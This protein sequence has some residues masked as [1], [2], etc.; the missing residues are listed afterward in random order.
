MTGRRRR[1]PAATAKSTPPRAH[2][3]QAD[4]AAAEPG[5]LAAV[6]QVGCSRSPLPD[7]RPLLAR[8]RRRLSR[9]RPRV[10][11]RRTCKSAYPMLAPPRRAATRRPTQAAWPPNGAVGARRPALALTRR[12]TPI[13]RCVPRG[14]ISASIPWGNGSERS[15]RGR[16]AR[17][18]KFETKARD[19]GDQRRRHAQAGGAPARRL[20]ARPAA[21]H[22]RHA[23]RARRTCR[24]CPPIRACRAQGRRAAAA[25]PSRRRAR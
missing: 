19:R 20:V 17:S 9:R 11:S 16:P 10:R 5:M 1:V 15:S 25:R 2:E 8:K 24:R 12:R 7:A 22:R 13:R 23:G 21:R 3:P 6:P 18:R 14:S 4:V